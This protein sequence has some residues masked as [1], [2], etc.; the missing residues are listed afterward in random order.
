MTE[1]CTRETCGPGHRVDRGSGPA[2]DVQQE[3]GEPRDGAGGEEEPS[4]PSW[5]GR[6]LETG[7]PF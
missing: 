3:V 4:G 2:P 5:D 1:C 7:G 6:G